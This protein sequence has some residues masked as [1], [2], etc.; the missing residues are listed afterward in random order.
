[1]QKD[2]EI[3]YYV[4]HMCLYISLHIISYKIINTHVGLG[5][6]SSEDH[7]LRAMLTMRVR[8]VWP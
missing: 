6:G 2:N 4:L 8:V 1:M 5:T 7:M 3:M